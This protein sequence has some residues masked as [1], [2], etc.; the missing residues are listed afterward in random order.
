[1]GRRPSEGTPRAARAVRAVTVAVLIAAASGAI[2]GSATAAERGPVSPS[3]ART[4]SAAWTFVPFGAGL[5]VALFAGDETVQ[6]VGGALAVAGL[7]VGPCA[8]YE[9]AGLGRRSWGGALGR[10]ALLTTAGLVA[11]SLDDGSTSQGPAFAVA[12][13]G[14]I[15]GI[16]WAAHD[17]R[18]VDDDVAAHAKTSWRLG[19]ALDRDGRPVAALALRF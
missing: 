5:G 12:S 3:H 15:G 10:F 18:R 8:G 19:P 14:L 7:E 1:M 11:Q 2:A 4:L 17:I 13:V 6:S 16:F 9:Y